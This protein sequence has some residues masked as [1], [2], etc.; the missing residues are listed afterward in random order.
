MEPRIRSAFLASMADIKNRAQMSKL[1]D[2]LRSQD[3]NAAIQALNIDAAAMANMQSLI[4]ETYAKTGHLT[5]NSNTWVYP[6]GTRAVA[7]W[8]M[9]LPRAE[10]YVRNVGGVLIQGIADDTR[11]IARDTIADGYAFS[12]SRD[13]IARDLVGRIGANGKRQGGVIG[14]D[15]QSKIWVQGGYVTRNGVRQWQDGL[16]Q[17]LEVAPSRALSMKL[18]ARDKQFIRRLGD[19]PMTQSQIDG[20]LRRYENNLLMVRGRRVART[21]T[22]DAIE[23]G[24]YE[25]WRQGLEKT[26][27]PDRFVSKT[28]QHTGRA[29]MD[30]VD[31]MAFSGTTVNG[32][33]TPFV[34][35]SG[36]MMKHSHDASLGAGGRDIVS[37]ECRTKYSLDKGALRTWYATQ[38]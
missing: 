19:G 31:H 30:R 1:R 35:P 9:L 3:I 34:L 10:Q 18:N 23:A 4:I 6:D 22:Q 15:E 28:W 12:R 2:A 33:E 25:A 21:E 36:A 16:R 20:M 8:D 32:L 38:S 7:R 24:R 17:K 29:V 27:I 37:C 14:L 5:V 26:G 13:R 11:Q